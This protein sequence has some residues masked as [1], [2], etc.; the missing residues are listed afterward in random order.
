M[1]T[2]PS[3][4]PLSHQRATL[5][6][7]ASQIPRF[8]EESAEARKYVLDWIGIL[9]P[10]RHTK[11][12][13]ALFAEI[14]NSIG[15]KP[16]NIKSRYYAWCE[17][18]A[19]KHETVWEG[20]INRARF[21]KPGDRALPELF[22][23]HWR[24]LRED[25]KRLNDGGRQAHRDLI[26][27]LTLWESKPHDPALAIPGYA[28]V[29][30]RNA[31]C[32]KAQQRV[33]DGWSY[34]NLIRHKPRRVQLV[35]V[36]LGPKAASALLPGNLATRAGLKYREI[37]FSDDQDYDTSVV[38]GLNRGE[39]MRPQGFNTL[40]YL[41]GCFESYGIQLRRRD[42][43]TG[44]KRGLDQ[45]AYVWTILTD[46]MEHGFRD[47]DRGTRI[48]R[49][50]ATAKGFAK[51]DGYGESFDD[52]IHHITDGRV[53]FDASGRFDQSM[54]A[55]MF[56][57]GRGKQSSGNFRYKAPLESAFH[58]VRT[59][60]AGFLG[61]TGN[62]Y[63]VMPEQT[64]AIDRYEEKLFKAIDKLP[65][66]E[67]ALVYDLTRHLK[68]TWTEFTSLMTLVYGAVNARRDHSL[69]G[70]AACGFI[71][72]VYALPDPTN[73]DAAPRIVTRE[74]FAV[75]DSE[76][77]QY[78]QTFARDEQ[79]VLSPTEARDMCRARDR[80]LV[81]LG[82]ERAISTLPIS[83]AYPKRKGKPG[84]VKVRQDGTLL[85]RDP[86]RFGP[87]S[88]VYLAVVHRT[89]ATRSVREHLHPGQEFLVHVCPFAPAEA[90][91]LTMDGRYCGTVKLMPRATANDIAA[92]LRNQGAINEYSADLR[93]DSERRQACRI[94]E[95]EDIISHNDRLLTREIVPDDEALAAATYVHEVNA[96][97]AA[98][99]TGLVVIRPDDA[100]VAHH[101][102][103]TDLSSIFANHPDLDGN[104]DH[105]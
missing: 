95:M 90:F 38:T 36:I 28:Q 27:A 69:E 2:L 48:I 89:D 34:R 94:G 50:H 37:V 58:R 29:P 32:A 44:R 1:L 68:H 100:A 7:P 40:D 93:R 76:Q 99:D 67:R 88:L 30:G 64:D 15:E 46:L 85:I 92:R 12:R 45:E 78:I 96:A 87:E 11:G 6:I 55:Q 60:M 105:F 8:H 101:R 104:P 103:A 62:R 10:L 65:A 91:V 39:S 53:T 9:E 35:N 98:E 79:L 66:S 83:W 82:K 33:P 26:T 5:L 14:A 18:L 52:L 70:W 54:F 3:L 41:T 80:K 57:S 43:E 75:M 23:E 77:R 31:F 49:E 13:V 84:G 17:G 19:G 4:Q 59:Q 71:V 16:G 47:D 102:P 81:T 74:D 61:D 72:P 25:Q 21:P 24:G 56:C 63:Q 42:E 51:K 22:L 86:E 73:R 97:D 20:L